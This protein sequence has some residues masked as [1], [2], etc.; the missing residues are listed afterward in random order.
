[1]IKP[2]LLIVAISFLSLTINVN[3][4][5]YQDAIHNGYYYMDEFDIYGVI[6]EKNPDICALEIEDHLMPEG[7]NELLIELASKSVHSW[8][9]ALEDYTLDKDSW[10]LNFIIIPLNEQYKVDEIDAQC[11]IIINFI[12]QENEELWESSGYETFFAY[13]ITDN[14]GP[15]ADLWIIY[16]DVAYNEV[17]EPYY[18][19]NE[20]AYD[21]ENTITHELGHAFSLG[22]KPTVWEDYLKKD[23]V[24]YSDSIMSEPNEIPETYLGEIVYEV[25]D[26]DVLAM[27]N[28]YGENGFEPDSELGFSKY[29]FEEPSE[30]QK[31]L[32]YNI[33][34]FP[35]HFPASYINY[36][37]SLGLII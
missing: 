22:H 25:T 27:I 5:E 21:L 11:E 24:V 16:R 30:L 9:K 36:L 18:Y 3:A 10:N 26:Y 7:T 20:I 29:L 32:K 6:A 17:D 4:Q 19:I 28:L 12:R 33:K 14:F 23:G 31:T 34:R 8:E 37:D 13:A 2:L 15:V 35:E 1:M